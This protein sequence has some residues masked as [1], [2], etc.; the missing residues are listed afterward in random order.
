MMAPKET[1]I[2]FRTMEEQIQY[3]R[4]T[5]RMAEEKKC[6]HGDPSTAC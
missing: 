6:R 4:M 2:A 5:C 1:E 3:S